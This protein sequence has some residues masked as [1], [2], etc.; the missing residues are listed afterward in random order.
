MQHSTE[1]LMRWYDTAKGYR[2]RAE[3][4]GVF[5]GS[6][7][8]VFGRYALVLECDDMNMDGVTYASV[9]RVLRLGLRGRDIRAQFH[10]LPIESDS[11]ALVVALHAFEC[12]NRRLAMFDEVARVLAPEGCLLSVGFNASRFVPSGL[13]Y[14]RM[15]HIRDALTA[16]GLVADGEWRIGVPSKGLPLMRHAFENG[17]DDKDCNDRK[18]GLDALCANFYRVLARPFC[19]LAVLRMHKHEVTLTPSVQ[20]SL[21]RAVDGVPTAS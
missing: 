16:R 5:A 8:K 19:R 6:L 3:L 17:A 20:F 4:D 9:D 2:F 15:R 14:V 7:R 13:Q 1:D 21:K 12:T 11:V 18:K 10:A